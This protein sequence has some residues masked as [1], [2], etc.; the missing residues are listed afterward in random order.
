MPTK[1]HLYIVRDT[2]RVWPDPRL[3]WTEGDPDLARTLTSFVAGRLSVVK[4]ASM[5]SYE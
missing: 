5:S 4:A 2:A 3:M 1:A